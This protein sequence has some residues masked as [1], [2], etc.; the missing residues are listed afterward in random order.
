MNLRGQRFTIDLSDDEDESPSKNPAIEFVQ[1]IKERTISSNVSAPTL[2]S[3]VTGFPKLEKRPRISQFKQQ[4]AGPTNASARGSEFSEAE[5]RRIDE[6]NQQRL[7]QMSS[8]E[9]E[10]E[11]QELFSRLEPSLIQRLLKRAN[12]DE[13]RGDTGIEPPIE[14]KTNDTKPQDFSSSEKSHQTKTPSPNASAPMPVGNLVVTKSVRFT[15][16]DEPARPIG[17]QQASHA[18]VPK[19]QEPKIHF[20]KAPSAPE[21]EPSDPDFLDSLHTKY[22]PELPV[23]PSRLAWMAP[24]PSHGSKQ[25]QESPYYPA[26]TTLPAS[27]L[28][29]NFRGGILPPRIARAVPSTKGLHHHAEAPE[30]AG[31]TIPELG[32]LA[33]SAFPAQRCIAFQT[34]GRLLYRLGRGEWG[35][36]ESEISKGLWHC[37]EQA[38]VIS[39]L[40][41]AAAA[42]GGHQGSK[43][44]AVEAVWLWQKGGGKTKA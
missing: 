20:P 42:E 12:L 3:T 10:E 34:L 1:D 4:K 33:R 8:E 31:Y 16:D 28:R 21:L 40:E 39:T 38:R 22:F 35:G 13:N 41:Q 14:V 30:A 43:V 25:D 37:V 18:P 17:L 6:E 26:Q 24:I 32:H 11:R 27:A 23:D 44:Y 15:D 7:S 5:K 9:V 36:E 29:F 2:K 19:I